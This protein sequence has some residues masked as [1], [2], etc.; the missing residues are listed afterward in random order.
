ME[1][2]PT[3]VTTGLDGTTLLE[4]TT[5]VPAVFG[6]PPTNPET[7][8][9]RLGR[10]VPIAKLGAGGM[11]VVYAAY[12]TELARRVAVKMLPSGPGRRWSINAAPRLRREAR[13]LAQLAHPNVVAIYDVGET[14]GT[15]FV[16]M[17]LVEGQTLGAW[18][19]A[20]ARPWV[21]VVDIYLQA[22]EGLAAAH[23]QGLV[24]RDF[25]PDNAILDHRGRVRV[26]DF[27][28][29][30]AG[31]E[32][33]EEHGPASPDDGISISARL[34]AT[35]TILGT[36]AYM[37]IEQIAG[38]TPDARSDQFSFCVA[39]FE[40]LYGV[41]PFLGQSLR[42]LQAAIVSGEVMIPAGDR[43]VPAWLRRVVLRGLRTDPDERWPDMPSL[44]RALN[45]GRRHVSRR[46]LAL[47][48]LGAAL[49]V[50]AVLGAPRALAANDRCETA[51]AAA[52]EAWS[53]PRHDAVRRAIMG[54]GV[55]YA[56]EA[57]SR[58]EPGLDRY[59]QAWSEQRLAV[60]R[61]VQ[62]ADDARVHEQQV[63]CLDRRL[64]EMT[65]MIELMADADT[66]V[67]ARASDAVSRLPQIQRCER[68]DDEGD[69]GDYDRARLAQVRSQLARAHAHELAGRYAEGRTI[70]LHAADEADQLGAPRLVAEAQHRLGVL[71]ERLADYPA[72]E[73]ALSRAAWLGVEVGH[74]DVA[75]G[76]MIHLTGVVGYRLTRRDD[77]L[78]WARH[79]HAAV[80]RAGAPTFERARLWN[81]IGSIHDRVGQPA[82]AREHY[83]RAL[84][85][86][87]DP[88]DDRSRQ[89]RAS[90]LNNLGSVAARLGDS[91]R[92]Q[93]HFQAAVAI[94]E[95]VRGLGH[96]DVAA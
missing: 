70:A 47:A 55:A 85:L 83:A 45:Q 69:D 54:S 3:G 82:E 74:D 15:L 62:R 50:G 13:A 66:A 29:A 56:A 18:Q 53:A 42:D 12:D 34:T 41:R 9:A 77:G 44:L 35:G 16:A 22:G 78:A 21:E 25:K 86:L 94:T 28:L 39:L 32:D 30:V 11:G 60:C 64:D 67:V 90:T 61:A 38:A 49:A 65:A 93:T 75:A 96:P 24:H 6:A 58:V 37:A 92:A 89:L 4:D 46:R 63:A 95:A 27:G 7:L 40:A 31:A 87:D 79:A 68:A 88:G 5:Q 52:H 20:T 59:A 2:D 14:N 17:E 48:G 43:E 73:R 8:P 76:A 91:A 26:L 10:Y 33:V 1:R 84:A 57:W 81:T 19:R 36:P 51:A 71:H 72:A 80:A 23:R